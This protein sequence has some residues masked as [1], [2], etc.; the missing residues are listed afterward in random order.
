MLVRLDVHLL[1]L[2]PTASIPAIR[3]FGP[4]IAKTGLEGLGVRDR[5]PAAVNTALE[6]SELGRLLKG[7]ARSAAET[8]GTPS[9]TAEPAFSALAD[10]I[11]FGGGRDKEFNRAMT[12]AIA[13]FLTSQGIEGTGI[14]E[15][16][17]PFGPLIPDTL[18]ARDDSVT[19]VEYTWRKGE[20]VTAQHRSDI[21]QYAL[22]KVRNYGHALGWVPA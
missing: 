10:D 1:G 11:G 8:R 14:A 9:T 2:A 20:F 16:A 17:A 22:I 15:N 6:R 7:D 3:R 12:D 5:G 13:G 18:I 21:A 19:C 4:D